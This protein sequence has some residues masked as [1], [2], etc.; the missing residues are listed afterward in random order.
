MLILNIAFM[1]LT[2]IAIVGCLAR[3]VL[4]QRRRPGYAVLRFGPPP[5]IKL[6]SPDAR[7]LGL[8]ATIAPQI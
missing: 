5:I 1:S 4:T 7:Q 6:V 8:A 2:A 3:S